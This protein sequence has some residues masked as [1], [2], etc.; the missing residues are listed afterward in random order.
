VRH[1][2]DWVAPVLWRT[3]MT[4]VLAFGVRSNGW[5]TLD[6]TVEALAAAEDLMDGGDSQAPAAEVLRLAS[7]SGCTGNDSEF[8]IPAIDLDVKLA[9]SH[10]QLVQTFPEVTVPLT[11]LDPNS[12]A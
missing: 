5:F 1:D 4:N 10:Q 7:K 12:P 2:R 8:V 6:Q 9:T 3:E 11:E